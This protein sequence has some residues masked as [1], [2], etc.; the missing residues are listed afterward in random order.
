MGDLSRVVLIIDEGFDP[1][2]FEKITGAKLEIIFYSDDVQELARLKDYL[3]QRGIVFTILEPKQ[4]LSGIA[5]SSR[6]SFIDGVNGLAQL[7]IGSRPLKDFYNTRRFG[8]LWYYSKLHEKNT[9]ASAAFH[10]YCFLT[11]VQNHVGCHDGTRVIVSIRDSLI[12]AAI[13]SMMPFAEVRRRTKLLELVK[14]QK[15]KLSFVRSFYRFV[16]WRIQIRTTLGKRTPRSNGRDIFFTYFPFV[17]GKEFKDGYLRSSYFKEYQEQLEARCDF[18]GTYLPGTGISFGRF[19]SLL[20]T[21]RNSDANYLLLEFVSL[22]QIIGLFLINCYF[23]FR[24]LFAFRYIRHFRLGNIALGGHLWGDLLSSFTGEKIFHA[25][26]CGEAI[27]NLHPS[28]DVYYLFENFGWERAVVHS[29]HLR[30]EAKSLIAYQHCAF[31]DNYLHFS[32]DRSMPEAYLPDYIQS[33]GPVFAKKLIRFRWKPEKLLPS[34][35]FRYQYL[36]RIHPSESKENSLLILFSI[37]RE[38]SSLFFH[39]LK[40]MLKEQTVPEVMYRTHPALPGRVFMKDVPGWWK[41]ANSDPLP[42]LLT[43]T[44]YV[45]AG[46]GGVVIEALLSGGAILQPLL[47]RRVN[48]SIFLPGDFDQILELSGSTVENIRD[49]VRYDDSVKFEDI[50]N[51]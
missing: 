48:M 3:N 40:D 4:E 28:G 10:D 23:V 44:K 20:K 1:A 24:T 37:D 25:M 15:R 16:L 9:I 13:K 26:V 41:E 31:G 21:S 27:S 43:R 6:E 30:T 42:S 18:V 51:S 11:F 32:C 38:E 14:A 49:G 5:R 39:V 19:L 7:R 8:S 35:A 34:P 47:N 12:S 50:F 45:I 29:S 22:P 46:Q 17:D 2:E 36:R 33:N